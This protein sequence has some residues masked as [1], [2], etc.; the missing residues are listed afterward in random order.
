MD[1]RVL[2]VAGRIRDDEL[3]LV[4]GEIAVRDVDRDALLTLGRQ[5]VD[6]QRK[7]DLISPSAYLL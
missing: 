4:G 3:A 2:F 6:K 1:A 5:T 7:V